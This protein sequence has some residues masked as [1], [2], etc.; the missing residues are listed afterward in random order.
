MSEK[1]Y[2]VIDRAIEQKVCIGGGNLAAAEAIAA[3]GYEL[4]GF[5]PITPS[6]DVGEEIS[7]RV[8]RGEVD[9]VFVPAT[10]ELA[11]ISI[12][13]GG[14]MAGA[15]VVDA[16]SAQGLLLKMEE[17]PAISGLRIPMV[18]NLAT[19]TVS[20]P[21]NI[22]N[23]HSDLMSILGM[24]WLI[25]LAK[26]VQEVYDMNIVALKWAEQVQLPCVVAYDGFHTSH[27]ARRFQIFADN[28]IVRDFIGPKPPRDLY[29]DFD[30]P[31]TFGAYM[32][33]DLINNKYQL[34]LAMQDAYRLLP[35]I[36]Q[37]YAKI[38]GRRYSM[39]GTVGMED[40]PPVAMLILNSAAHASEDA[41]DRIKASGRS[42]GLVSMSLL[43]PFPADELADALSGVRT[44]MVADRADE[45]GAYR[46]YL[47]NEIGA[48]LQ[49]RHNPARILNRVY[50]LGGLNFSFHDAVEL[51]DQALSA[52]QGEAV[53]DFDYYGHWEGDPEQQILTPPKAPAPIVEKTDI[54]LNEKLGARMNVS[55]MK[56]I[57]SEMPNR[58]D[59]TSA[60]PGCGAF[61][62]LEM[63]LKG[64]D[65][66]VAL[67]YNTG[68]AEITSSGFP[69]TSFKVP[70]AHNLF[71]NGSST[72][73]GIVAYYEW[74]K[75][76]G[77]VDRDMTLLV[78]GGDGS[79]DIG[80]DQLIGAAIRNHPFIYLEYDN[81]IYANTGAQLCYTGF[82]GMMT[83]TSRV[84]KAQVG[85]TFHSK[86]MVEILRGTHAPYIATVCESHYEDA[87]MKAREAQETV[88]NG[89]F[90][91]LKAFSTCPLNWGT[92]GEDGPIV[93]RTMVETCMFPLL[94][95]V[96]GITTLTYN[97]EALGKKRPVT[98]MVPLMG[99][100]SAHLLKP[101]YADVVA[102]LQQEVDRRWTRLKAM[103]ESP[104]L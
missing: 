14:A 75:K 11:A 69:F 19:R 102:D 84:G 10:S 85:K 3:I 103:H 41:V 21:L 91:F 63:V 44:L 9:M 53:A 46:S 7:A 50:G 52:D 83:A 74:L 47:A 13:A 32:N 82:K 16:T 78:V 12:C 97:P 29:I 6:S 24:G 8:A 39:V 1:A 48:L 73:S 101:E 58:I 59:K 81:N 20:A 92:K 64:I 88:R 104:V 28:R 30:H 43:R 51:Y 94:K 67:V 65:G 4:E 60:C 89:G 56:T 49:A 22:K 95:I 76:H 54:S 86:D 38:S 5:Y 96:H 2:S 35:V 45:Y 79:G 55:V 33:D 77:R 100:A 42:V 18:L 40:H 93:A 25:L 71:H 98:D 62:N 57:A 34:H 90:A 31:K 80:M 68:C 27:G 87:V 17:L 70:Y 72:A 37:E 36:F 99:V 15:R 23:D 26:S 66:Q 61:L